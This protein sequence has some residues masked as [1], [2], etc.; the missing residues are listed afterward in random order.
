MD[1]LAFRL[2]FIG[3]SESISGLGTRHM[4]PVLAC[5]LAYV[6]CTEVCF[7]ILVADMWVL[8]LP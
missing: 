5:G 1:P 7:M 3:M 2:A 8:C 6:A 4:T